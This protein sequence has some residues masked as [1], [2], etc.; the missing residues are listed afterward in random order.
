M[1]VHSTKLSTSTGTIMADAT[2][3][4]R[5][6]ARAR[7]QPYICQFAKCWYEWRL[8]ELRAAAAVTDVEVFV[9]A[10]EERA[11]EARRYGVLLRAF[12]PDDE[13]VRRLAGRAVLVKNITE[14]WGSGRDWDEFAAA[15]R[16]FPAER[17]AP[18]LAAGITFKIN[19][20]TLGRRLLEEERQQ[21]IK[22]LEPLLAFR[23][24]VRMR[25]PDVTFVLFVDTP[26]MKGEEGCTSTTARYR[27]GRWIADGRRDLVHKYDLKTRN[28]IGTTSLDPELSLVMANLA[29][30]RQHDLVYDPYCGTAGTL[31]AAAAF[32][33]RVLGCDL[34]GP[35]I[36]GQLRTRSGP[37]KQSWDAAVQG[38]P[39]TFAAYGLLPPVALI[40]GDSGAHLAFL[41]A[42][43]GGLFD[44][45]IT[46][47][48]Y[49]IR[50]KPAEVADEK[51]LS[52][53]IEEHHLAS[54]VP[55]TALAP[56]E[57]ILA[58]LFLLAEGSLVD[59]GRLVFLL[60]TTA[61]FT[62]AMLLAP[63]S[64]VFEGAFEQMMAA[65]WS[66]WCITMR[67]RPR[68]VSQQHAAAVPPVPAAETVETRTP[69][70]IF[71]RA[72]L[73]PD[74]AHL[75]GDD[76][77][78]VAAAQSLL[79][80]ELLKKSSSARRRLARRLDK[81]TGG[82]AAQAEGGHDGHGAGSPPVPLPGAYGAST[83]AM[84]RQV[85]NQGR[86]KYEARV[87]A[88]LGAIV[89]G[90]DEGV[91]TNAWRLG[92]PFVRRWW[93]STLA[94]GAVL[95]TASLLARAGARSKR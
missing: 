70:A 95:L 53:A 78:A 17:S 66:R 42:V 54:H 31:V 32:G 29:R 28:Y 63:P 57:H 23:G 56:I 8:G 9:D 50:E 85:R 68:D 65:R 2:P 43:P 89:A 10:D 15:L 51:L 27:F 36:R 40:Q 83:R 91:H 49:G 94:A 6:S 41:R 62:E 67:R 61:P 58:D 69:S 46:D 3:S 30:L 1:I 90:H 84:R 18:F 71:E 21:L 55:K 80:P 13:A 34:H 48:P 35:A 47:P 75:I 20:T 14:E 26:S 74:D 81:L 11:W 76:K 93:L 79:H 77:R 92:G 87:R 39:E 72:V 64:L 44:A 37:G 24:S 19:V 12:L 16:A 52:R 86:G 25:D 33:A 5:P 7:G 59:G 60:P 22:Q 82:T 38:I 4:A 73:R 45:I 88:Q